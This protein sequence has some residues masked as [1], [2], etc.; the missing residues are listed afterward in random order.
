MYKIIA[1]IIL[2]LSLTP[3]LAN[4]VEEDKWSLFGGENKWSL[5]GG[6]GMDISGDYSAITIQ[7]NWLPEK[8]GLG[9][10]VMTPLQLGHYDYGVH[11]S[12]E[13]VSIAAVPVLTYH[14]FYIGMGVSIGNTTPNLGTAWNFR[15][16]GGYIHTFKNG[17]SINGGIDHDSHGSRMG[18]EEDKANGGTTMVMFQVG[19]PIEAILD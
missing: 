12:G 10:G 13:R 6:A 5:S 16:S 15:S 1:A 9:V 14:G 8:R 11:G 17:V 18:I 7:G 19:I 4:E 2:S 3:V